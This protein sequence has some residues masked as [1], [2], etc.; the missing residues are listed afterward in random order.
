MEPNRN[1]SCVEFCHIFVVCLQGNGIFSPKWHILK[2]CYRLEHFGM[3]TSTSLFDLSLHEQLRLWTLTKYFFNLNVRIFIFL[4]PL[5]C[6]P[7]KTK[8]ILLLLELPQE[9]SAKKHVSFSACLALVFVTFSSL[10]STQNKR[11]K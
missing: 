11:Y 10:L 6:K 5:L 1:G 3:A 4:F 8:L 7:K 9:F 2:K